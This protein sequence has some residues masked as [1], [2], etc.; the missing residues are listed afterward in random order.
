MLRRPPRSTRTDT[1][2]PYTTLFRSRLSAGYR[3]FRTGLLPSQEHAVLQG[4][5]PVRSPP[6]SL[7]QAN[8]E[9]A[10]LLW[11]RRP[12][13][14]S[15]RTLLRGVG[16]GCRFVVEEGDCGSCGFADLSVG[17]CGRD[18]DSDVGGKRV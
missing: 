10:L 9:F 1:L 16:G 12:E 11:R 5:G 3:T 13:G 6:L 8:P 7:G 18:R 17:A 4:D 2:F 15:V 14:A